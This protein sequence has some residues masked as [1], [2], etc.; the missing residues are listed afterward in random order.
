MAHPSAP[1]RNIPER[2]ACAKADPGKPS[3]GIGSTLVQ[4]AWFAKLAGLEFLKMPYSSVATNITDLVGGTLNLMLLDMGSSMAFP[5]EG[6]FRVLGT[7]PLKRH[8]LRPDWPAVSQTLPGDQVNC[9][10][11]NKFVGIARDAKL[12]PM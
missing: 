2:I 1:V 11:V 9:G 12:E 6:K 5:K 8:P 7:S 3:V 4:V 10:G